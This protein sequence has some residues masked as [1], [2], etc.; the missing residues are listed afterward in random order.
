MNYNHKQ[1]GFMMKKVLAFLL[2]ATLMGCG[3]PHVNAVDIRQVDD[4]SADE[5]TLEA[6]GEVSYAKKQF[7]GVACDVTGVY[8]NLHGHLPPEIIRIEFQPQDANANTMYLPG[9]PLAYGSLGKQPNLPADYFSNDASRGH[10]LDRP[11]WITPPVHM[12]LVGAYRTTF[13]L[14]WDALGMD[15]RPT[16]ATFTVTITAMN[17]TGHPAAFNLRNAAAGNATTSELSNQSVDW[18]KGSHFLTPSREIVMV[19]DCPEGC[20]SCDKIKF[21]LTLKDTGQQQTFTGSTD[22]GKGVDGVTPSRFR[23]WRFRDGDM[24]YFI[25]NDDQLT[26]NKGGTTVLQ[27]QGRWQAE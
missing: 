7:A 26:I 5:L 25:S 13:W 17:R 23:G 11:R 1:K 14:A 24:N 22:H 10:S 6:W 3:Q 12:K 9:F 8:V 20:V 19:H 4:A 16:D 18:S 2:L 27:E 21:R 15:D